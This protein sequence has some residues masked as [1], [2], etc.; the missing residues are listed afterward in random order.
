MPRLVWCAIV[1]I[2]ACGVTSGQA[3]DP[4]LAFEVAS[5]KQAPPPTGQTVMSKA[6]GG[7]GTD[8]PTSFDCEN[9]NL[10][11]LITMAYNLRSYELFAPDWLAGARFNVA[12]RVR[13][14]ATKEEFRVMLQNFLAERF[15]LRCHREMRDT[16]GYELVV[17]KG[18]P[19]VKESVQDPQDSSAPSTPQTSAMRLELAKDGFPELAADYAGMVVIG[20]RVRMNQ[21]KMSMETLCAQLAAQVTSPVADATGLKG[22]YYIRLYWRMESLRAPQAGAISPAPTQDGP[23]IWDAI[24]EQ[25]GL[26]LQPKKVPVNGLVVDSIDKT[27]AEN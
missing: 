11:R 1:T 14:G 16:P 18:G 25:L 24:Q 2:L 22:T 13:P 26:K 7:P 19:K 17:A 9:C 8:D 27:P 10:T 6:R 20:G 23:T 21:P 4:A 3:T 15:K 12:A 5:I